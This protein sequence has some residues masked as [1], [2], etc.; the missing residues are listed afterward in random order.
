MNEDL[1]YSLKAAMQP[2][3]AHVVENAV[4][5]AKVSCNFWVIPF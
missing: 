4:K 5:Y 3:Y 1:I 2:E